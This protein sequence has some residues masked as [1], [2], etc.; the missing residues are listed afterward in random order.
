MTET[1]APPPELR[2]ALQKIV[3]QEVAKAHGDLLQ[4]LAAKE[5]ELR[6]TKAHVDQLLDALAVATLEMNDL[7]G[8]PRPQ[9]DE[10]GVVVP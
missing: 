9:Y 1:S 3:E 4:E 8:I 6:E 7:R 2:A 5:L 10:N